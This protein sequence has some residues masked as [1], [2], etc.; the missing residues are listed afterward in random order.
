MVIVIKIVLK[1]GYVLKDI[2]LGW[3]EIT[4]RMPFSIIVLLPVEDLLLFA[5]RQSD[6]AFGHVQSKMRVPPSGSSKDQ[7]TFRRSS[8]DIQREVWSGKDKDKN[9]LQTQQK[10]IIWKSLYQTF[11]LVYCDIVQWDKTDV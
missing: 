7:Q 9:H 2:W 8:P 1:A 4:D 10:N 11:M 3:S 5:Y 6:P